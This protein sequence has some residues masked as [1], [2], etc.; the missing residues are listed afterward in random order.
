MRPFENYNESHSMA[1]VQLRITV[2]Q[3][4]SGVVF[5]LRDRAPILS[6]Q[7]LSTGADIP[8]H[9]EIERDAGGRNS[10]EVRDGSAGAAISL[11]LRRDVCRAVEYVLVS[12]VPL[13]GGGWA[14]AQS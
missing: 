1:S 2:I 3:P 8:F 9:W 6:Q 10:R 12:T 5:S 13:L 4:P 14:V 7:T 11:H